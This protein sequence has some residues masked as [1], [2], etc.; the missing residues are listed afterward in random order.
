[1]KAWEELQ[2]AARAKRISRREF[3]GRAAALGVSSA[4]ASSILTRAGYAE[5][6]K[7][8]G[9]LILGLNGAGAGDSLDPATYTA[10]F[11][12]VVGGQIYETLT[13][14]DKDVKIQPRLAESW[15]AKPDAKEWIVKI[16]KGVT[17]HNGK[18]LT[19]ADVVYSYNHH[20]A[21]D[22]KSA[23][24]ALLAAF[25][26]IKATDTHEITITLDGGNADL[27]YILSDYHIGIGPEGSNFTDGIGSGCFMLESSEPGVR[28]RTKLNPNRWKTDRGFVDSVESIAINDTTARLNALISGSAHIINRVDPKTVGLLKSRPTIQV[29]EVAGAA[30]YT[31]PMR[32][33]M[34]P[35]NNPDLRKAMKYAIDR[36]AI[37]KTVLLGHGKAGNDQPIASFD[38][39]YASDL[40]QYKFDADQAK[41][42]FKKSGHSGPLTLTVSDGAFTGAV[43]AAQIFQASAL[44][45]GIDLQ[46]DRVP[47]DGYWDNVWLK[48]PF[49]ASYW[50]GRPTA[51][52]MLTLVYKSD[53]NWN[54]SFWK[55]PDFDKLLIEARSELDLAKRK[56]MYHDLE[57]MVHDDSGVIIPMFNNT[58]DAGSGKVKGF[59]PMPTLQ[60]SGYRAAEK[61]WL[62]G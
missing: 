21:K 61:V 1:M 25:S 52:Q 7:K 31:F 42:Y 33:D 60:M 11:M 20:R 19:A 23:A 37:V 34:A 41:F 29:Y 62:E 12:Q 32:C 59:V 48:A 43:D 38:P 57:L 13:E 46:L 6:P 45:A 36:D 26:D 54:E 35:F 56:Q 55:R 44:K 10:T 3:M 27:P 58:I 28:A 47:A 5:E 18:S 40:P 50:D 17:F 9:H 30:H 24:K 22:S 51:D 53:A 8:G 15:E 49:C 14:V 4:L 16:R 39:N 2:N